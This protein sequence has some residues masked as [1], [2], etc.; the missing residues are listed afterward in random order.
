MDYQYPID[1]DWSTDEIIIVVKFFESIEQA[2][3]KGMEKSDLM[4]QYHA[5]KKIVPG[6]AQEKKVCDEFEEVSGYSTYRTI[7]KAKE[8]PENSRIKMP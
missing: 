8:A 3:E 5:F 2:Y 6:K 4:E 1:I 7:K